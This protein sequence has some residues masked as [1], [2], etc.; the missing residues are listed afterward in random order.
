M[1][2]VWKLET[3]TSTTTCPGAARF[4]CPHRMCKSCMTYNGREFGLT[5]G[6]EVSK[7]HRREKEGETSFFLFGEVRSAVPPHTF[8]ATPYRH[9]ENRYEHDSH[10]LRRPRQ[11]SEEGRVRPG[12]P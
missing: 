3:P 5:E 9:E 4:A 6:G 12:E 11:P 7:L 10:P 1:R 8:R 2:S